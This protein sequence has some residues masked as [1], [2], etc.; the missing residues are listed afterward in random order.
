[1]VPPQRDEQ[2]EYLDDVFGIGFAFLHVIFP[3]STK[4]PHVWG[5]NEA[6]IEAADAFP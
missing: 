2:Q 1:M 6:A 5:K 3:I 4:I